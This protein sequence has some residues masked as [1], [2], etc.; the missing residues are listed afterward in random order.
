MT[1]KQFKQLKVGHEVI[2]NG[3][4]RLDIGTRC[5]VTYI[6][7]DRIWVEPIEGK[8]NAKYS[9]MDLLHNRPRENRV[10]KKRL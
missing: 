5:K 3:L 7:D 2:L 6:C 1:K 8:L 4:C 10:K 9:N